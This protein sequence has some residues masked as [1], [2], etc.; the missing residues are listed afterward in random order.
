MS[1]FARVKG[2]KIEPGYKADLK[3]RHAA[4]DHRSRS[5]YTN[6]NQELW[7]QQAANYQKMHGGQLAE[8]GGA[9]WGVWQIPESELRVLGD[10]RGR[11]V[12]ELGCGA[13]Q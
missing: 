3:G 11:D 6:R 5:A 8:S 1:S 2:R 10:V 4:M 7:D 12:L 9:A 13:A